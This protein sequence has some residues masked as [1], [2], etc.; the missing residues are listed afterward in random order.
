M[1]VE[2]RDGMLK[3]RRKPWDYNESAEVRGR[4]PGRTEGSE[5]KCR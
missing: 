3:K 1:T 5:K 2:I 4:V